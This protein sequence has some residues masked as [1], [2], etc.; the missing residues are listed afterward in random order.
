MRP[1]L[2]PQKALIPHCVILLATGA[3]HAAPVINEIHY[4]NDLNYIANEFIELHNPGPEAVALTGWKLA[5][6]IDFNFPENSILEAGAYVV[7]AKNP[8]TLRSEF[9]SPTVDLRVL[10]PYAGG[11]SGEG[12]TIDLI[13]NSGERIDRVSFDIDFPWPIAA[14]GAGS[15]MELIHPDLDNDL[16]SSWRSSSN[17]GALGPPTPSAANSVY[18]TVAPPNI[19]QVRHDPQQPASTEDLIVTAKVTDPDGVDAKRCATSLR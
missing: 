8:A 18:S 1:F 6:G 7:V 4:N 16:G 5:G 12:E 2:H 9:L 15:S 11:L 17:N 13:D 3:L 10:G 14:D 19:R